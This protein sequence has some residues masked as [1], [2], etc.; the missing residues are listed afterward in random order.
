M[1]VL[2]GT[3]QLGGLFLGVVPLA[4]GA[5]GHLLLLGA[6]ILWTGWRMASTIS[7]ATRMGYALV[8]GG[9]AGN[10]LDRIDGAVVDFFGFGPVVDDKWIFVNLADVA[11]VLG[12]LV[13]T[14]VLVL[15]ISGKANSTAQGRD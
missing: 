3:T 11:M 12:A 15:E 6:A 7:C 8:T 13:L 2:G 9:L 4:S 5:L 10:A 1:V 14:V